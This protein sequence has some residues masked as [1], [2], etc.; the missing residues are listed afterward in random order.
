M[1]RV[2]QMDPVWR[3]GESA[4]GPIRV[5]RLSGE[6]V[7]IDLSAANEPD[8]A[9]LAPEDEQR[10]TEVTLSGRSELRKEISIVFGG[11]TW[12]QPSAILEPFRRFSPVSRRRCD[13]PP[14]SHRR[15]SSRCVRR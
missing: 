15:F 11:P 3:I 5:K 8:D 7:S 12:P 1:D 13:K 14:R 9:D 10:I 2:A 6:V 4:T